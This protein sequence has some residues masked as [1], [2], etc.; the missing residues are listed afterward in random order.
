MG[1]KLAKRDIEQLLL[2]HEEILTAF[3]D[4]G[5]QWGDILAVTHMYLMVHCPEAREVYT[6]DG[7]SPEFYYGP[8]RTLKCK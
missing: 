4:N 3:T 2:D 8:R 1:I 7:S 5:M 6:E